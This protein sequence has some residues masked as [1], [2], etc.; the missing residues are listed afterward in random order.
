MLYQTNPPARMT[1]TRILR[2]APGVRAAETRI[3]GGYR[4]T[5]VVGR[6]GEGRGGG[7]PS[8]VDGDARGGGGDSAEWLISDRSWSQAASQRGPRR[9]AVLDHGCSSPRR[10]EQHAMPCYAMPCQPGGALPDVPAAGRSS[11]RP[12]RAAWPDAA[13]APAPAPSD[14]ARSGRPRSRR[15]PSRPP[16]GPG[17]HG[18]LGDPPLVADEDAPR[19]RAAAAD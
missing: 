6:G 15:A 16:A 13:P 14:P 5:M 17:P 4:Y 7:K 11:N 18:D 2:S 1:W 8:S 10:L 19:Q 3:P 12:Q 9:R